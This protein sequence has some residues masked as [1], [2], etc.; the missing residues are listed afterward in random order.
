MYATKGPLKTHQELLHS[1]AQ[2]TVE[3]IEEYSDQNWGIE[4]YPL[5][6]A[7]TGSQETLR[8]EDVEH[9]KKRLRIPPET[10]QTKKR[11]NLSTSLPG[12][13]D[14]VLQQEFPVAIL[15]TESDNNWSEKQHL[16]G[17]QE[18]LKTS[19][20]QPSPVKNDVS[21]K[22]DNPSPI[23]LINSPNKSHYEAKLCI[24]FIV[25]GFHNRP[26]SDLSR[27]P[28]HCYFSLI[29]FAVIVSKNRYLKHC[30]AQNR[31]K[32]RQVCGIRNRV[33]GIQNS[34]WSPQPNNKT[35]V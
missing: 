24:L 26:K 21:P 28:H 25:C 23:V 10:I 27:N 5:N 18:C 8:R 14:R 11:T 3:N 34:L 16:K 20:A 22:I 1:R 13:A 29:S 15:D 30:S 2:K 19:T 9:K 17:T 7:L 32:N 4:C 35:C 33:C 31:S 6:A 12:F